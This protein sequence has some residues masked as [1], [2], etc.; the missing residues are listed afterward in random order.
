MFWIGRMFLRIFVTLNSYI[1]LANTTYSND[2]PDSMTETWEEAKISKLLTEAFAPQL[3]RQR[4]SDSAKPTANID[5]IITFDETGVSSHPNHISL[6]HGARA[7]VGSLV[8]GKPGWTNPVDLYTL[9]SVN[10]LRKYTF[11]YD[12]FATLATFAMSVG[13]ANKD[14]PPTLV[15][16][17]QLAGEG[18]LGT[19]WSAMTTAHKSQ[20]V[21]FRYLWIGFSRYMLMNDLKREKV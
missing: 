5:V 14:R 15:F 17:N 9:S 7:F 19:A 3:E 10:M 11:F 18:A 6:Y 13:K 2:F 16:M 1:Q 12:M 21:W 4:A 20:M 8:K